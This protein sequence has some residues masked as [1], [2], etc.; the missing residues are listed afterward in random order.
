MRNL[1]RW[2]FAVAVVL[3]GAVVIYALLLLGSRSV[4]SSTE[5]QEL[6]DRTDRQSQTIT[7]LEAELSAQEATATL[8]ADQIESLGQE[9]VV[10]PTAAP[11]SST[12]SAPSV[13]FIQRLIDLGIAARCADGACVGP[14]GPAGP[15]STVPGPAGQAGRD[16][17]DSTVPGPEGPPGANGVNGADGRGIAS[18]SCSS[19]VSFEYTVTYTDGSTQ[20]VS[21]GPS[22]EP[23]VVVDPPL[24]PAA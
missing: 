10:T 1:K 2:T 6:F 23:P 18:L 3:F 21:C 24:E 7:N 20:M 22:P 17:A 12:S 19:L 13:S 14:V 8:L 15:P 9:P 5:R 4:Q 16:G 11:S